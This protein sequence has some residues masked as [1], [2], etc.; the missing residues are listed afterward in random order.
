MKTIM[1][2]VCF[3]VCMQTIG[4]ERSYEDH[5]GILH[6]NNLPFRGTVQEFCD[7]APGILC[8][9]V[10]GFEKFIALT[11]AGKQKA[12]RRWRWWIY[13]QDPVSKRWYCIAKISRKAIRS[14]GGVVGIDG[15]RDG[16]IAVLFKGHTL[17]YEKPKMKPPFL[18]EWTL[19]KR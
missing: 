8:P 11:K 4:Q 18:V 12:D 7:L 16:Y 14:Y 2:V 5:Y 13:T 15:T 6:L 1:A 19:V 9:R 17:E 3:F 10:I